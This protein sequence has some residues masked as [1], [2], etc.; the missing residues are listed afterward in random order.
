MKRIKK[1][2]IFAAVLIVLLFF[3]ACMAKPDTEAPVSASATPL[4]NR[5]TGSPDVKTPLPTE[6]PLPSKEPS[7]SPEPTASPV[8]TPAH[9]TIGAVGDIMIPG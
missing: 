9:A 1:Q 2:L 8:P 6:T 3:S 5:S 7:P 4:S